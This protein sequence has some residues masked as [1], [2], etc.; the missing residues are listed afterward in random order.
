MMESAISVT[1]W[2]QTTQYHV[3]RRLFCDKK[4]RT[5]RTRN[6]DSI[7]GRRRAF[8]ST[9]RP[10]RV[11]VHPTTYTRVKGK[12]HP[13]MATKAQTWSRGMAVGGQ[14]HAPAA[15]PPGKSRYPLYRRLGESQSRS[16]QVRKISP[17]PGIRS[18]DRPARSESL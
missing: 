15:L 8:L 10:Y 16:R 9:L 17:L 6:S 11:W 14:R 4:E 3:S 13:I 2:P 5:G 7:R 1:R 12:L 18:P